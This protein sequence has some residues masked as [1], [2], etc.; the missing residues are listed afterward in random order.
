MIAAIAVFIAA[1]VF[2]VPTIYG[3]LF[4]ESVSER[5]DPER[6]LNP[7]ADRGSETEPEKEIRDHIVSFWTAYASAAETFLKTTEKAKETNDPSLLAAAADMF[8][9]SMK[10]R[11]ERGIALREKYGSEPVDEAE[12]AKRTKYPE[13]AAIF[14]KA[15]FFR[16]KLA[17]TEE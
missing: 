7:I 12:R 4:P 6:L 16:K 5:T 11:S 3:V 10:A 13:N 1:I 14:D 15:D 9:A 2:A 8:S 17:G